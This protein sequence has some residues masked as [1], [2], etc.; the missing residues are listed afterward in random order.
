MSRILVAISSPW[1]SE[2]V[3]DPVAGLAKQLGAEVLVVHVSRPSGGQMREQEQADGESAIRLLSDR[4]ASKNIAVQTL[5]MFSDDI[6]RAILN[7]AAEREI[8][9]IVLGMT[10]VILIPVLA[11]LATIATQALSFY[12]WVTPHLQTVEL[13]ELWTQNLPPQLEWLK[14]LPAFAQGRLA[15]FVSAA[16]SR[17]AGAA[18][19]LMQGAV[20][21]LSTAAFELFLMLIMLYFFLRDGPQFRAQIRRVSPLSKAQADEVIH[22][23]AGT[24]RGALAQNHLALKLRPPISGPRRERAVFRDRFS[25]LRHAIVNGHRARVQDSR[26]SRD[27]RHP[28][29]QAAGALMV[30]AER[31]FRRVG[32]DVGSEVE[33][34]VD[35]RRFFYADR[36][37]Q[38]VAFDE[39][40]ALRAEGLQGVSFERRGRRL[41]EAHHGAR[42]VLRDELPHQTAPDES[43]PAGDECSHWRR[44][45]K[46]RGWSNSRNVSSALSSL[47]V[48]PNSDG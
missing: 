45:T 44:N 4:L 16:L 38:K 11:I 29:E 41:Y 7:T 12:E 13:E 43:R 40:H 5:L 48:K 46:I 15:D 2:K 6:A 26:P 8:S 42:S 10:V 1:A 34:G 39:A 24:M 28:V 25:R 19:S 17:L 27:R 23:V 22:Q 30:D 33:D 47:I 31:L 3:A 36:P 21:G 9:L 32:V 35:G 20:T 37:A 18:N 14:Q